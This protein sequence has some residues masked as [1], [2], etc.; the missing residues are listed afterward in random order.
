VVGKVDFIN[1]YLGLEEL[2]KL[3]L[4]PV[5]VSFAV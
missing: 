3:L 4:M 2:I 5:V 1:K